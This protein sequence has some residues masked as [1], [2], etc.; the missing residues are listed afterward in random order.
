MSE[1]APAPLP[2]EIKETVHEP[3]P[4]PPTLEDQ[5][6]HRRFDYQNPPA[7]PRP[8]LMLGDSVISTPGN[9]TVL[10]AQVKAGKSAALGA[11]IAAAINPEADH[12]LCLGFAGCNTEGRAVIHFDTEQSRFDHYLLVS[13]ALRRAG[14]DEPPPCLRSYCITDLGINE[15]R[16]ALTAEVARAGEVYAVFIDGIA[17]LIRDPNDTEESFSFVAELHALAIENDCTIACVLHENPGSDKTRGHLGSQLER[18]AET[19]LRLEKKDEITTVWTEKARHCCIPKPRGVCFQYSAAD[20]MHVLTDSAN[21]ARNRAANDDL[22]AFAAS[23]FSE[24]RPLA[25]GELRDR[26]A[27]LAGLKE[28]GARRRLEV[29]AGEGI[30]KKNKLHK[31]EFSA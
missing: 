4:Q 17:D 25:W 2:F 19:P 30:I 24:G 16:A 8:L 3:K 15:R 14:L 29:M 31:Y 22:T 10:S 18:K 26:I 11:M 7:K 27:T 21:D 5:L 13:R 12:A 20:E 1:A 23:C 9:L 6:D 28:S